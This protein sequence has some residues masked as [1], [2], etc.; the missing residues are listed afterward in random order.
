MAIL[1]TFLLLAPGPAA[2]KVPQ[3]ETLLKAR[4]TNDALALL[5]K[6]GELKEN[7]VEAKALVKLIRKPKPKM[8]PEIIEASFHAL[9]GIESREITKSL[10]ML[11]KVRRLKKDHVARIGI[12]LVLEATGDPAGI[13]YLTDRMV[14]VDDRV[15]AAAAAA[16]GTHRHAKESVRKELFTALLKIFVPTYN[17]TKSLKGDHKSQRR[18]A[19]RKWELI[20]KP[21]E[22]SLQLL[23]NHTERTPPQ[24]QR[25]W[26][27]NKHKRWTA[28][29]E[30]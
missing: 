21:F 28:R 18:R 22:K 11:M 14:D 26:N 29:Q 23:S 13:E 8:P 12:C 27:K 30:E 1:L 7:H 15:T 2:E 3:L 24:W 25:W 6:I 20:E 10:L 5:K 9:A 16:M 19:E 4:K 17:L